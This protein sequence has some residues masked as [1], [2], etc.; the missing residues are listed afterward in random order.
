MIF[1]MQWLNLYIFHTFGYMSGIS[2]WGESM[3][4]PS[5]ACMKPELKILKDIYK[6]Q[7]KLIVLKFYY[8]YNKFYEFK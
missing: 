8:N 2:L 1:P 5:E 4:P 6:N 3:V 7:T